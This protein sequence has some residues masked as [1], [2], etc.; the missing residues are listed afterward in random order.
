MFCSNVC[1]PVFCT[2]I[3]LN[4]YCILW[5]LGLRRQVP[6]KLMNGVIVESTEHVKE[7]GLPTPRT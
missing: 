2:V 6:N 3:F 5:G 7:N 1:T 4:L